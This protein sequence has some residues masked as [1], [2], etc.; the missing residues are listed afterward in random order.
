MFDER[1]ARH[2][3]Y[4]PP[5]EFPLASPYLGIV[6]H[7]SGPNR[8]ALTQT[9][10]RSRSLVQKSQLSLSL[11]IQICQLHTRTY[12]RLLGPCFKTGEM[13][14]FCQHRKTRV[15]ESVAHAAILSRSRSPV[16]SIERPK[17][18]LPQAVF[19]HKQEMLTTSNREHLECHKKTIV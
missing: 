13:K 1:F 3:R 12:V 4:E 11:R 17:P 19:L 7:L 10:N 16:P 18:L 5:P 2:Y 15:L 8:Y 6:H 9:S 14:S